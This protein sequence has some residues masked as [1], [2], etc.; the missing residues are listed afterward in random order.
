MVIQ[1]L[2]FYFM[3]VHN[4][5]PQSSPIQTIFVS[6]FMDK[7]QMKQLINYQLEVVKGKFTAAANFERR[8]PGVFFST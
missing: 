6:T 5:S 4:P 1:V 7:G 3:L 8:F 2:K